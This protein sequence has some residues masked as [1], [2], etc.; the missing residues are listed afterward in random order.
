MNS[1]HGFLHRHARTWVVAMVAAM[2][3]AACATGPRVRT[4]Y[5]P[6][7]D[8]SQYR[9]WGWYSPI[10]ME[11]SGY[12]SWISE[13]IKANIQREMTARGY[14]FDAASP[15]LKV[16]FQGVVQD[17]TDVHSM[18]R[19][20]FQ[21]YWSYRA[22]TYVAVPVWYDEAVVSNY[23]EG[24]LTVDLV[25]SVKNHMVWTGDAIGRVVRSKPEER[26]ADLDASISAI[27]AKYPYQAGNGQP[28]PLPAH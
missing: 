8:F 10:A 23:T 14:R 3:L 24:T 18:P 28:L 11:Q 5:D 4:D 6:S 17:R 1:N 22:R 25:D 26:A 13:R 19:A 9:T 21:Y 12:S 27:F 2:V 15:D 20:D 7:A 16:N